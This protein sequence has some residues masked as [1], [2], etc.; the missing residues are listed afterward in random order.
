MTDFKSGQKWISSAEP[1]LGIG[2]IVTV[3][4]RFVTMNFDLIDEIR[5]YARDQAPLTRVKFNVGDIIRTANDLEMEVSRVSDQD[6]ILVYHGEY[7]G[8]STAIIETELDPSISFSKP[9][10]RLFSLQIDDNRWFNL[11]YQTL[12]HK[13]RLATSSIKGLLG[14]RVSLIPHQFF[15]AHEVA[16]R[17]APRV[18]LADEV[19]LGKTIEAGLII[20]Q[21]L[22]TSRSRR[23]MIIV[24]PAL[25]FQ[26]FVE[27]IRRFNLKFT[28]LDEERCKDIE[29]DN[30][31]EHED[32]SSDLDNPFDAQQLVL[33][34]LDLFLDNPKRLEQSAATDWDLIVIDEAHHLEW[35]DGKPGEDYTAVEQL[36]R[37]AKGLLLLT[38]TPEQLGRLG[39]FSRLRLLDPSRYHSYD[40]FLKEELQYEDVAAL[41]SGLLNKEKDA[42]EKAREKLGKHAP[43]SDDELLPALLD[44]HGTGRVL[45]RNVRESV[46]GF[47]QRFLKSYELPAEHFPK[48]NAATWDSKDI[49]VG[50]LADLLKLSD[51][52]HLVI[53]SR[54]E[55]AIALD[56]YLRD[57]T[58]IRSVSFHQG[59][60]LVARDRA[61]NYF[62]DSDGGAQV[63]VCSEI[64]SEGRNFQFAHQLVMYDLPNNPDLL[65]QRIGRLDRIGQT[66]DVV[67]HVPFAK[68]TEQALLLRVFN[69]GFSIFEK[70]NAAA[71]IV[72]D[73]LP[74][75]IDSDE[76]VNIARIESDAR[77]QQL[78]SGRDQLLERN[79]HQPAVSSELLSQVSRAETDG[80]LE[81]YMEQSFEMFGLESEP[82][83]EAAFLVK[84][85]E[86]MVRHSSVSAET[87]DRFRY[88]ELPEEGTGYTFNRPTALA[89]EDLLFLTW[90]NPL[91][92]QALDMVA[93]DVTGNSAVVVVKL[94]G[95]KTGTMLAETLHQIECVAPLV[96][97]ANQYLPPALV[98]SLITPERQDASAQIPFSNWDDNLDVPT[99]TIAKIVIQQ[100]AG[101]KK[102]LTAAHS[103]AQEKFLPIKADALTSMSGHLGIEVNRLKALAQVNPNVRPEEIEFLEDRLRLLSS[104]IENSQIRLEAVRLIIAA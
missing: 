29:A 30:R 88:P 35:Q 26:W 14:P 76:R 45:F 92:E 86:S 81:I 39:H 95:V 80:A 103:I 47:P 97:N 37:V 55:T 82:L 28:L 40:D 84:P 12:Q 60:D 59:L 61:A 50:W 15:I 34:S 64:G 31:P 42:A 99:E 62:A 9:E 87:Q 48:D 93:S 102:L 7:Q 36:S 74:E 85:T 67:I 75:D 4:H 38:A 78:R 19:G 18:L 89:R 72:F 54:A 90:E 73:N 22:M 6:G 1:E 20:H 2:Q 8:T 58:T 65:E 11:R 51:D 79:S 43:N 53:C 10:E 25:S 101:I 68:G 71:Q 13:A 52:K 57:R 98:R 3:E 49:R 69:E 44:R 17:Y 104:A 46:E 27:M 33:C 94:K 91:V 96:L 23:V 56:K 5:T 66:E 83:S 70:P 77:L 32:D 21:Q 41:V 16:A 100:E 63:L 24:P